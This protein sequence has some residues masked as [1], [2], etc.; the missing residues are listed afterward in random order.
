MRYKKD[1]IGYEKEKFR[2]GDFETENFSVD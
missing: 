1:K 2:R